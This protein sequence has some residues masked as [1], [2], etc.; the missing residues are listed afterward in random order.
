MVLLVEARALGQMKESVSVSTVFEDQRRPAVTD[1]LSC[2]IRRLLPSRDAVGF[3]RGSMVVRSN[4]DKYFWDPPRIAAKTMLGAIGL[5]ARTAVKA[6][7]GS[8]RSK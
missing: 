2:C 1:A 8:A 6:C 3:A 4:V 7:S 5:S